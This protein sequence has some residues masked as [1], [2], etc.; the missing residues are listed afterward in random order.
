MLSSNS[1]IGNEL[2]NCSEES[3]HNRGHGCPMAW[4]SAEEEFQQVWKST[5]RV[6][7]T[8]QGAIIR[9]FWIP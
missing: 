3:T 4:I 2:E 1:K 8:A 6:Q 5:T 7:V 9:I